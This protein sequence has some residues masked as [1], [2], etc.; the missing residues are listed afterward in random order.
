M[1]SLNK[2]NNFNTNIQKIYI[3][4]LMQKYLFDQKRL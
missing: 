1:L 4:N 3:E 2:L